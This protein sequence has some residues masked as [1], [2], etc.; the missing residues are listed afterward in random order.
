MGVGAKEVRQV[1]WPMQL[2][3]L[4]SKLMAHALTQVALTFPAG[5]G[6]G[7]DGIHPRA[8]LRLSDET[9]EWLADVLRHCET[10]VT[11]PDEVSI[12][13]I[14]LLPKTD[15]GLRPIGLVPLMPRLWRRARKHV[16]DEW[17][18]KHH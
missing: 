1:E 13:I 8:I 7:W 18:W 16:V 14:A 3:E 9:L 12:V 4:P 17:D 10:T 6:L 5:T 11:W 2:G 15:G